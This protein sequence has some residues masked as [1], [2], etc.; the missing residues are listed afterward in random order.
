MSSRLGKETV[1]EVNSY[2]KGHNL[3]DTE[4]ISTL[5]ILGVWVDRDTQGF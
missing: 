4:A 3:W 5:Q 1:G 2:M